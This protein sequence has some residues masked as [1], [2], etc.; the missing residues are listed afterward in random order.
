MMTKHTHSTPVTCRK[1][2]ATNVDVRFCD[3]AAP[4]LGTIFASGW[5]FDR[6]RECRSDNERHVS[7]HDHRRLVDA[8]G[9]TVE[10]V[11]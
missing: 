7:G 11:V 10:R 9:L 4:L 2:C 8:G 1:V 3:C 6:V 5:I